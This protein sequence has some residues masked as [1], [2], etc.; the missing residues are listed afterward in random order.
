LFVITNAES[1][2]SNQLNPYTVIC[3]SHV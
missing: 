3:L 1:L 2:F